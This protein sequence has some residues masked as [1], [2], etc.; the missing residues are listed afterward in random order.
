MVHVIQDKSQLSAS[1][2]ACNPTNNAAACYQNAVQ[3]CS[4][5][6]QR[7]N[8]PFSL[9]EAVLLRSTP[10]SASVAQEWP[11]KSSSSW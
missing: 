7:A 2:Q 4:K 1:A 5:V 11:T 8:P 10:L 9:L 6:V 3:A